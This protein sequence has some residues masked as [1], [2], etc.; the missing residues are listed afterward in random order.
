MSGPDVRQ[1]RWILLVLGLLLPL[2][3]TAA[4]AQA[5]TEGERP[6]VGH[7]PRGFFIETADGDWRTELQFRFQFRL[8]YPY[9]TD[10]TSF[11]DYLGDPRTSLELNRARLKVGGHGFRPW[12]GYY[13][14]Y[15]LAAS[16]LL[17]F[18]L[19]LERSRRASV[20]VGQWKA[21][22]S[23]ERVISSGRQQMVD[24]SLINRYF[25]LDRQQGVSLF[26][27][28]AEGSSADVSYWLSAFTGTGR[29]GGT[30]DDNHLMYMARIQWN[31][32]GRPVPF[33]GSELS[34]TAE[35]TLS[36]AAGAV[37]NR[38]PC[39]RFS[40]DGCGSL[41]RFTDTDD[42]RYRV[43]Q[44]VVETAFLWK[45]VSWT[46]EFH[47]KQV[48]DTQTTEVTDLAGNYVQL[49]YFPSAS[50]T[51]FPEPLE[52]A[53]RWAWYRPDLDAPRNR[54]DELSFAVNWFFHGHD[55]K[56]TAELSWLVLDF[57]ASDQL[58][59][60]GRFRVQWDVQF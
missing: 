33:V 48:R 19:T 43:H 17:N 7:G 53:G 32:F 42:G 24:R 30:N 15:E 55:S 23:R 13:F 6:S 14:E 21:Q 51:S 12:L 52:I 54:H 25:T 18:E 9:D 37:T 3:P 60:G 50:W 2:S 27:R 1:P 11:D 45:G 31:P 36:L 56:L 4:H 8:S 34:R 58:E 29:G 38:S 20:R 40:Q 44:S 10:P 41:N 16:N 22:Y 49:G 47:W 59:E 46:Q 5:G 35:P 39:T 28:L 26:G 57:E